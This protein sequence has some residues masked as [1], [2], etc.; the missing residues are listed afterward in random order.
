[1]C[2][3]YFI[4]MSRPRFGKKNKNGEKWKEVEERK[5]EEETD[6]TKCGWTKDFSFLG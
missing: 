6:G 3:D 1:M 2:N 4:V 5:K